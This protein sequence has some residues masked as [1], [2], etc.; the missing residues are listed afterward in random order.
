MQSSAVC[1]PHAVVLLFIQQKQIF[2]SRLTRSG[3]TIGKDGT[4]VTLQNFG[5]DGSHYIGEN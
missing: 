1:L 2:N 5:Q 3:L 4:V